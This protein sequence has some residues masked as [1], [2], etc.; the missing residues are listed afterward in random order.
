MTNYIYKILLEQ[1][2]VV[3]PGFGGF[4][5]QY[6][7]SELNLRT[8]EI[9]P[10]GKKIAFN[11]SLNQ[12][13]GFLIAAIAKN[14]KINYKQAEKELKAYIKTCDKNLIA[15]G[16][17]LFEGI[18]KIV[19]TENKSL[20]F[21]PSNL[22]VQSDSYGFSELNIF[23]INRIKN[24]LIEA[25]N[26]KPKNSI[27]SEFENI[28]NKRKFSI[29]PF[30]VTAS[31]AAFFMISSLI[32]N[33]TKQNSIIN[34]QS[35][36]I[37]PT[38]SIDEIQENT[39]SIPIHQTPTITATE[40]IIPIVVEQKKVEIPVVIADKPIEIISK[41]KTISK[42]KEIFETKS[43]ENRIPI[44]IDKNLNVVTKNVVSSELIQPVE[45]QTT[46]KEI[47]EKSIVVVGSFSTMG[48]AENYQK[49]INSTGYNSYIMG[50]GSNFRVCILIKSAYKDV[51]FA[52]IKSDINSKAWLLE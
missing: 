42:P 6:K 45:E 49:Q 24:T 9:T 36:S 27:E 28:R 31:I 7:P 15:N 4:I 3:L 5:T 12:N 23:P 26:D 16:S 19:L 37:I 29:W 35:A 50:A 34:Q 48:R 47:N 21:Y 44:S 20:Q 52:K 38:I 22:Q 14:E 13:D 43:I 46:I 2:C 18:G 32:V 41:T 1:D 30:R 8:N 39:L 40:A 33:L 51:Q 25:I 11:Q 17:L 10:P